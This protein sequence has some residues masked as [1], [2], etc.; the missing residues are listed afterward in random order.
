MFVD[1]KNFTDM[2]EKTDPKILIT[3]LNSFFSLAIEKISSYN[4]IIDKFIGDAIMVEFGAPI[5]DEKHRE[6]A[7][8]CAIELCKSVSGF[9]NPVED[10]GFSWKMELGIGINSGEVVLG[11][12]GTQKRME[13]TALGDVVNIASRLERMTREINKP[14]I[15][16]EHTYCEAIKDIV[17]SETHF[18]I[19]GKNKPVKAYIVKV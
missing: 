9:K 5:A 12:I 10:I 11:N 17:E 3:V 8:R 1:I 16:G 14:I 6:N 13:Y 7:V 19:K 15:I 4:G 18:K 2:A